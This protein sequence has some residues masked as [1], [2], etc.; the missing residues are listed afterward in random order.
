MEVELLTVAEAAEALRVRPA[1]IRAWL[2]RR[3]IQSYRL[4]R[5]VRIASEELD[6]VLQ[7]GLRPAKGPLTKGVK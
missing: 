5:S 6:R 3:K 4:G 1:T 7:D 2:L